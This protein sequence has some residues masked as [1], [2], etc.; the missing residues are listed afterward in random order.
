MRQRC[1]LIPSL[2]LLLI[3]AP[4]L[5]QEPPRAPLLTIESSLFFPEACTSAGCIEAMQADDKSFIFRDGSVL[6]VTTLGT[7]SQPFATEIAQRQLTRTALRDLRAVL[8]QY[9]ITRQTDCSILGPGSPSGEET[10]RWYGPG[11]SYHR[12]RVLFGPP[13]A[14]QLPPCSQETINLRSSARFVIGAAPGLWG[15]APEGSVPT[16]LG[17]S[18]SMPRRSS[19]P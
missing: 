4:A 7:A 8:A 3:P 14:S 17:S 11:D 2:A 16:P 18:R 1:R 15:W 12:F 13:G 5:A 10:W 19:E 6:A 9:H